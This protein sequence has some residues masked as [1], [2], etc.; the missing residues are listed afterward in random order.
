MK[1]W[2][3]RCIAGAMRVNLI[4]K[5]VVF[6][7]ALVMWIATVI[8]YA[9]GIRERIRMGMTFAQASER[10]SRW[11]IR[12]IEERTQEWQDRGYLARRRIEQIRRELDG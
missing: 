5:A 1:V 4:R 2:M 7:P 9:K 6:I 11:E 8:C 10:S 3:L 12:R